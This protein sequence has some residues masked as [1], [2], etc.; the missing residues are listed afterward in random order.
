MYNLAVLNLKMCIGK[1]IVL[2]I[3]LR[4]GMLNCIT[5]CVVLAESQQIHGKAFIY[6]LYHSEVIRYKYMDFLA[7]CKGL[8][9]VSET[10]LCLSALNRIVF[11]KS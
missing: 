3:T 1:C 9:C 11:L 7:R 6:Y 2:I 4:S 5:F 8:N 10:E